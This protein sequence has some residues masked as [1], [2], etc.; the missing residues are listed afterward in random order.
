MV[1]LHK[2]VGISHESR[3]I[4]IQLKLN[5]QVVKTRGLFLIAYG[6]I[7]AAHVLC[8]V[9]IPICIEGCF[10]VCTCI[11]TISKDNVSSSSKH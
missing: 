7:E 5:V 10:A 2:V 3:F 6:I 1:H 8:T 9:L 11:G 4:Q